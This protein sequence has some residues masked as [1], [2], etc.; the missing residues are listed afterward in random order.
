MRLRD[1]LGD[2]VGL[3]QGLHWVVGSD[4]AAKLDAQLHAVAN[5]G[6]TDRVLLDSRVGQAGGGTGVAF[7]WKAARGVLEN[8]ADTL[9]VIVAGGLRPENVAEAIRE[10]KPWG[11]D[12]VT[13]VE[14]SPGRKD[15]KKLAAF[16]QIAKSEQ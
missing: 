13:G 7:D 8:S 10:L 12:V 11:V 4:G 9:R 3:I 2:G 1:L 5:A 14:T 15:P 6:T 16:L